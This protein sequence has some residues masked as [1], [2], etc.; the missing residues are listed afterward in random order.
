MSAA[1]R[2]RIQEEITNPQKSA[3][4][5]TLSSKREETA[6]IDNAA[7]VTSEDDACGPSSE[8]KVTQSC[9]SAVAGIQ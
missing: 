7:Y 6:G 5:L 8:A 2:Q 1:E 4:K 9:S 3:T